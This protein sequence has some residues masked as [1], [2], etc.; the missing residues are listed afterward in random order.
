MKETLKSEKSSK[1]EVTLGLLNRKE[2]IDEIKT[3]TQEIVVTEE[4]KHITPE[5]WE[6]NK[7]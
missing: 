6:Y 4:S 3:E 7:G 2:I 1:K 5:L